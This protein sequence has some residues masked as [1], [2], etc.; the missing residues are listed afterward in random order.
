MKGETFISDFKI[1]AQRAKSDLDEGYSERVAFNLSLHRV[2]HFA[3]KLVRDHK[4][5]NVCVAGRL[6]Q[7]RHGQLGGSCC[8]TRKFLLKSPPFHSNEK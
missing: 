5:Q 3:D 6:H 8:K 2:A 4:H 1:Q 7:V